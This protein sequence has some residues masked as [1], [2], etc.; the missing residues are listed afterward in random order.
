MS[1]FDDWQKAREY[2]AGFAR[3]AGGQPLGAKPR[4]KIN[5]W[6]DWP[7]DVR[8]LLRHW[9]KQRRLSFR[10]G[11]FDWGRIGAQ[12]RFSS[13]GFDFTQAV[14]RCFRC[15]SPCET[16]PS[17]RAELD[18]RPYCD[19][20]LIELA[21]EWQAGPVTA[22]K[23]FDD[24][25]RILQKSDR[26]LAWALG[27]NEGTVAR[28]LRGKE[29]EAKDVRRLYH[30]HAVVTALAQKL[31]EQA[32]RHFVKERWQLIPDNVYE[33]TNQA[34]P[35]LFPRDVRR[36]RPSSLAE[37]EPGGLWWGDYDNKPSSPSNVVPSVRRR[38][39]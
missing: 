38:R 9:N 22:G 13:E 6:E 12:S 25:T 36:R 17:G 8:S 11:S 16:H 28:W 20:C 32:A 35:L 1:V 4:S 3:D 2:D 37:L 5:S 30:L 18:S 15:Q 10:G 23:A 14:F 39:R 27:Y 21:R 26:E 7:A 33:L 29:P 31:G 19:S 34:E 24:L